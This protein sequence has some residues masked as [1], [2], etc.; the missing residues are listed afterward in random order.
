MAR[1]KKTPKKERGKPHENKY[2]AGAPQRFERPEV[3]VNRVQLLIQR[4]QQR[5]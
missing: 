5:R 3:A 2:A 4:E 1:P